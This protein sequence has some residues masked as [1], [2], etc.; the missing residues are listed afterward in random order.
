MTRQ[1]LW[2]GIRISPVEI[3]DSSIYLSDKGLIEGTTVAEQRGPTHARI[4]SDGID[5]VTDRH[6]CSGSACCSVSA[7][8]PPP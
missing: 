4:T 8:T 2:E 5:C 1:A 7:S 6:R 3:E